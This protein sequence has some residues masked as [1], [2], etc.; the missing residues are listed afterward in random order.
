LLEK[1]G[2]LFYS[3]GLERINTHSD[4]TREQAH[5]HGPVYCIHEEETLVL[6]QLPNEHV[7]SYRAK[8]DNLQKVGAYIF[9]TAEMPLY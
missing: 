7:A 4:K 1:F 9:R 2:E 8:Y 6:E 3:T 5:A